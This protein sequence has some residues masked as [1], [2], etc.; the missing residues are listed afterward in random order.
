MAAVVHLDLA[1]PGSDDERLEELAIGLASELRELDDVDSVGPATT[2]DVPE[3]T[4]SALAAMAGALVL[5]VRP[6][7]RQLLSVL[8]LVRDWLRRSPV[9][10]TVKVTIDGD[11]LELTGASDELQRRVVDDWVARHAAPE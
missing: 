3:G 1:E 4:R 2:G 8:G 7:P 10:R 11:T 5:S 9:Q 6:S